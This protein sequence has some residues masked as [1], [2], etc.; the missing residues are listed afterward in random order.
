MRQIALDEIC[1][2][3]CAAL[4]AS[5]RAISSPLPAVKSVPTVAPQRDAYSGIGFSGVHVRILHPM[6]RGNGSH[7]GGR[8]AGGV[9]NVSY[10]PASVRRGSYLRTR[11]YPGSRSIHD[12]GPTQPSLLMGR[13]H[14]RQPC[15]LL[16]YSALALPRLRSPTAPRPFH[17][18]VP[19]L[20]PSDLDPSEVVRRGNRVGQEPGD[21][22]R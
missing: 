22:R 18:I 8:A 17:G 3:P 16:S 10:A 14:A 11:R 15:G 7:V 4:T 5:I 1:L 9:P 2:P 12:C 20:S 13:I 19:A 6:S 21:T